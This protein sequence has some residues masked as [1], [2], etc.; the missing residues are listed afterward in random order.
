VFGQQHQDVCGHHQTH[1]GWAK[2][3]SGEE[4]KEASSTFVL[5]VCKK[6]LRA[7]LMLGPLVSGFLFFFYIFS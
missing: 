6:Q 4:K 2:G 3:Q 7:N 5:Q 1:L